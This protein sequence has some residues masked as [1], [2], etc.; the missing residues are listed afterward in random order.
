MR[1]IRW[2]VLKILLE[3][4]LLKTTK[5]IKTVHHFV[6][7]IALTLWCFIHLI[8]FICSF[9][10][11]SLHSSLFIFYHFQTFI[12]SFILLLLTPSI[13]LSSACLWASHICF[14]SL[15]S[16]F[17]FFKSDPPSSRRS[18]CVCHCCLCP[19]S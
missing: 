6:A 7:F 1:I 18:V 10:L 11:S 15:C 4:F 17:F 14:M 19:H 12:P 9:T 8:L 13:S 5:Q 3:K 2:Q 16:C